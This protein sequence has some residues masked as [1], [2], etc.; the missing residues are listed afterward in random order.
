VRALLELTAL[1]LLVLH[2]PATASAAHR[3]LPALPVLLFTSS[4]QAIALLAVLTV[5]PAPLQLFAP[6][7]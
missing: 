5:K 4:M 3:T 1:P 2:V 7:V 6:P